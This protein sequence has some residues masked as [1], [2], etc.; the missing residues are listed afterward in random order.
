MKITTRIVGKCK[1]LDCH[2]PLTLGPATAMIRETIREAVQDDTS[3]IVLNLRE[4]P[5]IDSSGIGELIGGHIH[6]KNKGGNLVLLSLDPK[7]H[8]LLVVAKLLTVFDT[9]DDEQKALAGCT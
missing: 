9:F 7:V 4:V 2:G 1:I 6:V 8:K 5:Y 3:K